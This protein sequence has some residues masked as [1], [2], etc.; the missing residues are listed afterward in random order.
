MRRI[1]GPEKYEV[2]GKC[3][4]LHNEERIICTH[5]QILLR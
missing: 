3:K 1:F 5:Y 2:T 4:K